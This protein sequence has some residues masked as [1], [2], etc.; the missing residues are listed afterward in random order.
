MFKSKSFDLVNEEKTKKPERLYQPRRMRWLKYIILPAV[1]SFA[2]LLIL[3]NVDFSDNSE[4]AISNSTDLGNSLLMS[5]R[6][7]RNN[8]LE[9][10]HLSSSYALHNLTIENCSIIHISDGTF[11]QNS[12]RYLMSLQLV[13]V[14]LENLTESALQGLQKLQNF[15]LVNGN[16]RFRP[17]GFLSAVAETLVNARVHQSYSTEVIYTV[18]DFLG[19][20]NF[21]ELT[22]LD[23]SGTNFGGS[24]SSD[25]FDNVPALEE[26]IIKDSGLSQI[27]WDTLPLRLQLMQHLDLNENQEL[28]SSTTQLESYRYTS[29]KFIYDDEV[30]TIQ[31]KRAFDPGLVFDTTLPTTPTRAPTTAEPTTPSEPFTVST[32]PSACDEEKC[33]D[34]VCSRISSNTSVG[35]ADLESSSTC[36]DGLLVEICESECSTPTYFCVVLGVNFSSSSD[37]C[38]LKTMRCVVPTT[39]SWFDDHSGLVIG[40]GIGLLFVGSLLGMLIVFGTLR[41]KPSWLRSSKRRESTTTGLIPRRFEKEV[42][43]NTGTPIATL[44]NNEYITAYHRYLEQANH[45]QTESNKYI[46][47]PRDRAPSVPPSSDYPLP[48][49]PRNNYIYESCEVYEELP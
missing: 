46:C 2:L 35:S 36:K 24:L 13:N 16:N 25:S 30:S 39:A 15:T 49:P 34:L 28:R 41:L 12:T 22:F 38:S 18:A 3:V 10:S 40:L 14:Q 1:F 20:R 48:L 27:E 9:Y 47:P 4:E 17:Y 32:P 21:T 6:K 8:S 44:D 33:Q 19:S 5:N 29:E 45:R 43:G 31:A 42:Y 23:L 37:C 11:D 26:L 7:F